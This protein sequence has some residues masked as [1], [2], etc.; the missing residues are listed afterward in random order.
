MI[1]TNEHAILRYQIY[2]DENKLIFEDILVFVL[3]LIKILR[4][5]KH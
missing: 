2:N 1:V 3:T 4:I 5:N